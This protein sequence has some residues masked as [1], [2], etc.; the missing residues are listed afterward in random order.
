MADLW[1]GDILLADGQS[2]RE[3]TL[4]S[5]KGAS[6][7]IL[8]PLHLRFLA[9]V[10]TSRIP[11]YLAAGPSLDVWTTSEETEQ[12]FHSFLLSKATRAEDA[13]TW[14][15]CARS[16]SPIG[17][18][19]QVEEH[20][21][22]TNHPRLTEIL[23]YGT[24]TSSAPSSLP[25]PP[26]SS[27]DLP[28]TRPEDL[29]ELRVHALPLS[30]DLLHASAIP[31]LQPLS[32]TLGA[33]TSPFEREPHFLPR[34]MYR[35][36]STPGDSKR[37]RDIFDEAT[38]LHKKARRKGGEGVAAAA[39]KVNDNKPAYTYRKSLSIDT[40]IAPFPDVRPASANE[41]LSRPSS[42]ALSRSPSISSDIR[43]LSRKGLLDGPNKRSALSQIATVPLQPEEPTIETRN[44]EALSRVVMT[45]MRMHGLQQRKKN[46]SRR[47]S[48][49]TGTEAPEAQS[50]EA[51]AE[52]AVK[53]EDYK[54]I[55]HQTYKGAALALRSHIKTKPLH[56]Q[57]D[58]LRDVVE[59]LLAIF[60]TDP[61]IQSLPVPDGPNL[62]ATPGGQKKLGIPRS[63]HSHNSPFDAPSTTRLPQLVGSDQFHTGSPIEKRNNTP[64][65][66]T[67]T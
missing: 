5:P 25:T 2:V 20:D 37:K 41:I 36:L 33:P 22:T 4:A 6:Q 63:T 40:T 42:R 64:V 51:A 39:A 14:W 35:D 29:P 28:N 53:D 52:E 23:F 9:A 58:L 12:W 43:P 46:K 45:A 60:C 62:L 17:I 67:K 7:L 48:V 15:T 26:S 65:D 50:E 44:K 13:A 16:Q 19:T 30:C 66:S 61:F 59:K 1:S 54:L 55:Y 47:G 27:P 21:A 24:I 34:Q 38:Q 11:L 56:T 31:E 3:I 32:P 10:D 49:A 8:P 18:L 57:P